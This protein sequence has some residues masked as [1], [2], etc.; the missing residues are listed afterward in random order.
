MIAL[1]LILLLAWN[2]WYFTR[3]LRKIVTDLNA[4]KV[5]VADIISSN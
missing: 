1:L 3:R 2:Q 4:L 5:A